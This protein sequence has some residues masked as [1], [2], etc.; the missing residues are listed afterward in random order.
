[1][2]PVFYINYI[3]TDSE[4]DDVLRVYRG[5]DG[6]Y[7]IVMK[8]KDIKHSTYEAYVSKR[9]VLELVSNTLK[10]ISYDKEPVESIQVFT[11]LAPSVMYAAEDLYDCDVRELIEDT[12]HHA[13][14]IDVEAY[15]TNYD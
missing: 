11:M 7:R 14:S 8:F 10:S 3:Y 6:D 4:D 15:K 12:I 2:V 1:M 9:Q 5:D 13:M